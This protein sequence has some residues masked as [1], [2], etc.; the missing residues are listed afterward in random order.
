MELDLVQMGARLRNS[1]IAHGYTR[2]QLAE[3]LGVTPKFCADIEL[4]KK[5]MSLR[6]LCR[7]T[8]VLHLS[9]DYLLFGHGSS[10]DLQQIQQMLQHC[11]PQKRPLARQLLEV[12]L[13][14]LE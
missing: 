3:K 4:G 13:Q 7:L 2:E 11:P 8:E 1:R 10:G 9:A 6:T 5:G 14:A 12:F